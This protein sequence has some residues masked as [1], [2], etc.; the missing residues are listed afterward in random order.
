M[1][2]STASSAARRAGTRSTQKR[3]W[4]LGLAIDHG[5]SFDRWLADWGADST[6]RVATK[7]A[8]ARVCL[9]AGIS[10]LVVGVDLADRLESIVASGVGRTEVWFGLP[11]QVVPG[12]FDAARSQTLGF[13]PAAAVWT[14][15]E[16]GAKGVKVGM[17]VA[18]HARWSD[19]LRWLEPALEI[20]ADLKV[21]L[22]VEPY[23]RSDDSSGERSWFLSSLQQ[24][25]CV[26]FAKLDVHDAD[27]WSAVYGK[28][29]RPWLARS[30]GLDFD[31]FLEGLSASLPYGCAG[32]MV[33]AAVWGIRGLPILGEKYV[34]EL[35]HRIEVLRSMLSMS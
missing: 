21:G 30:E 14:A 7:R 4:Y 11:D 26:Q 27:R 15:S 6:A 5:V 29:F 18:P 31:G 12:D 9:D 25:E 2:T 23:F 35:T 22:I 28:S 32:T 1:S 24:Y 13:P 10:G 16:A 3:D 17:G 20:A 19:V 34:A 33:G 8:L